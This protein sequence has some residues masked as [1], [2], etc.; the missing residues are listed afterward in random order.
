MIF[1]WLAV[2]FRAAASVA[3]LVVALRLPGSEQ[4]FHS[5]SADAISNAPRDL[6]LPTGP[7]CRAPVAV[8]NIPSASVEAVE[9]QRTVQRHTAIAG[10]NDHPSPQLTVAI[11]GITLIRLG[12]FRIRSSRMSSYPNSKG[13]RTT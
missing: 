12:P 4:L 7:D 1:A 9:N 5:A 3:V 13:I 10:K 2:L 6:S 8:F 11:Q